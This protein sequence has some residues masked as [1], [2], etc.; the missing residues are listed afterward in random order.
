MEKQLI[1]NFFKKYGALIGLYIKDKFS[2]KIIEAFKESQKYFI[3]L[4]WNS[5]KNDIK[6]QVEN[7]CKFMYLYLEGSEMD[8]KVDK[9]LENCLKNLSLPLLLKPFKPL[10]KKVIKEQL[11]EFIRKTLLDLQN[12]FNSLSILS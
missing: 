3:R 7:T 1:I 10:I 2:N 4:L 6:E 5:V 12:G 8:E 9:I 11:K